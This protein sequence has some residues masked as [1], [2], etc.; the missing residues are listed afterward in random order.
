MNPNKFL[1]YKVRRIN[2]FP[3][4]KFGCLLGGLAMCLPGMICAVGSVEVIAALR[5]LLAQWQ[6]LQMDL[7]GGMAPL[8]FDFVK[9]L[10]LETA[11][12]LLVQLDD[13]RVVLALLFILI[14]VIGGGLLVAVTI[15]LLGWVY[16]VLAAL[17]G[18]L[19]VELQ[20]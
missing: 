14:S 16:N 3:L 20:E 4:A 5:A 15:L 7:L 9:L 10:G 6:T 19:E 18:G 2:L 12:A 1:R 8:E 11:Q 17:T 13:Q